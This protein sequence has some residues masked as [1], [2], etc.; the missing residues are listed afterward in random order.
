MDY[1]KYTHLYEYLNF[2]NGVL[3]GEA[4]TIRAFDPKNIKLKFNPF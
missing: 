2:F 4:V 3:Q 1:I